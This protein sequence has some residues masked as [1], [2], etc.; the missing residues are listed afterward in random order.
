MRRTGEPAARTPAWIAWRSATV[1]TSG[2]PSEGPSWRKSRRVAI[3][4]ATAASPA[5]A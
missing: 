4:A 1:G 5:K 3:T 2:L